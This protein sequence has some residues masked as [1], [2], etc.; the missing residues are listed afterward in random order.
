MIKEL[1]LFAVLFSLGLASAKGQS[2]YSPAFGHRHE[3]I[4]RF[5]D[6]NW[7]LGTARSA[8]MGG[9]FTSLGEDLS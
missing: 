3:D 6:Y 1:L 9:A 2:A 5:S 4:F 8:A 7:S